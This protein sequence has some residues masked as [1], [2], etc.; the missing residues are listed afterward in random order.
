[1]IV[2]DTI[3]SECITVRLLYSYFEGKRFDFAA[4]DALVGELER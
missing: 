2:K 4:G 3:P 1:M